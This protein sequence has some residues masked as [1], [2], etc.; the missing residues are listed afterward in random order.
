MDAYRERNRSAEEEDED[1]DEERTRVPRQ[2]YNGR[3]DAGVLGIMSGSYNGCDE[4]VD[5]KKA[6]A[7]L[8][9]LHH[10]NQRM[11]DSCLYLLSLFAPSLCGSNTTHMRMGPASEGVA[12]SDRAF[13]VE[14]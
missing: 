11:V 8:L 7:K 6:P 4:A 1:E 10:V 2:P 13:A 12:A 3:R 9:L 14:V 5:L